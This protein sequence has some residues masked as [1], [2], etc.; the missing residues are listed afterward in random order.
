MPSESSSKIV[1]IHARRWINDVL[2]SVCLGCAESLI[3]T[4][5]FVCL[6]LFFEPAVSARIVSV[7]TR[8]YMFLVI[9]FTHTGITLLNDVITDR[10]DFFNSFFSKLKS[11]FA[12]YGLTARLADH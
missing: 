10:P 2:T 5:F 4:V 12:E 6:L 11:Y 9:Y 7:S 8:S 1:P 3:V